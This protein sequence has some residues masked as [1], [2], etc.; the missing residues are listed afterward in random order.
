MKLRTGLVLAIMSLA[1]VAQRGAAPAGRSAGGFPSGGF[2]AGGS[3]SRWG[4]FPDSGRRAFGKGPWGRWRT[5]LTFYGPAL[6]WFGSPWFGNGNP[7]A[8]MFPTDPFSLIDNICYPNSFPTAPW[9][10]P[11]AP[12]GSPTAEM[13]MPQLPPL[14]PPPPL[15]APPPLSEEPNSAPESRPRESSVPDH[16]AHPSSEVLPPQPAPQQEYPALIVLKPGGMYS[17]TKY[18]VKNKNLYFI[19]TQSETLYAPLSLIDRVYPASKAR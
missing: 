11:T 14:P 17:A 6:S 9:G 7:C 8:L 15:F 10:S 18:W 12:W 13:A 19:T 1:A 2:P 16:A 3:S 5:P 4:Q